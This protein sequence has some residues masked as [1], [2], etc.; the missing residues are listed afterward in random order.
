LGAG[1]FPHSRIPRA[2]CRRPKTTDRNSELELLVRT[3]L[4]ANLVAKKELW[5]IAGDIGFF[6]HQQF[7][8]P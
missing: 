6:M 5:G 3:S 2:S 7:A 1:G 4:V 8:D